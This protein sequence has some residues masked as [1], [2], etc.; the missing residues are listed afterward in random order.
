M[1]IIDYFPKGPQMIYL[2]FHHGELQFSVERQFSYPQEQETHVTI[3]P[4]TAPPLPGGGAGAKER[5]PRY[6]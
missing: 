5:H 4:T 1:K 3:L 2:S 6:A